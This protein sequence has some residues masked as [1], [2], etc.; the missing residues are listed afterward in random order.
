MN[1]AVALAPLVPSAKWRLRAVAAVAA[2]V[3]AGVIYLLHQVPL[4][5]T[6]RGDDERLA[7]ASEQTLALYN[8]RAAP[9]MQYDGATGAG[10]QVS[11]STG[12]LTPTTRKSLAALG[13]QIPNVKGAAVQWQGQPGPGGRVSVRVSNGRRSPDAGLMVHPTGSGD[14]V[15]LNLQAVQTA[16][17]AQIE[18]S[19]QDVDEAPV[20]QLKFADAAFKVPAIA[21]APIQIEIPPGESMILT[22]D[23]QEALDNATLRLGRLLESGGTET[24][25]PVGRAEVGRL[26]SDSSFPRLRSV[27]QGVCSAPPGKLLL[28][29]LYP[30]PGECKLGTKPGE[31]RL[32]VT[33]IGIQ[34]QRV[35]LQLKGSGFLISDSRAKPAA[36]WSAIMANPL[37]AV[38]ILGLVFAVACPA[39]RLKTGREL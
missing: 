24:G 18:L 14:A 17:T 7:A 3:L 13:L 38:L 36:F 34:P 8:L 5:V 37:I 39:W 26:L 19:S 21:V 16:L 6:L 31:E 32:F 29:H 28:T 35:E 15:E 11:I 12:R 25:L 4:A 27:I 23:S 10:L 33:E 2:L 22:F 1:E 20:A 30:A 9:V